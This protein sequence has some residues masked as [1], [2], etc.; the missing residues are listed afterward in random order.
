MPQRSTIPEPRPRAGARW[1]ELLAGAGL[2]VLLFTFYVAS[3][4]GK[5]WDSQFAALTSE[6]ILEGEGFDLSRFLAGTGWEGPTAVHPAADLPWQLERVEGRLLYLFPPGTPVL[7]LPLVAAARASGISSLDGDRRY[8]LARERRLQ[9]LV[10]SLLSALTA[11]IAFRLARYEVELRGALAVAFV[12]GLGSSLWTVASRELWSHTWSALLLGAGW[13]EL[14]R[15]ESGRARRPLLLGAIASAAFWVRPSNAWIA[16]AWTVFVGVRYRPQTWR[17][18]ASGAVGLGTYCA[19]SL[20]TSGALF[21]SYVRMSRPW[22][23]SSFAHG[24]SE[25]LFS[26]HHGILVYSPILFAAGYVLLRHGVPESK[27]PLAVLGSV[28]ILGHLGLHAA[29]GASWGP[30]G[31][32]L[33]HDL[34]PILAWFGAVALRRQHELGEGFAAPRRG[35]RLASAAVT[36]TLAGAS[37]LASI[38]SVQVGQRMMGRYRTSLEASYP[39]WDL[40]RLPQYLGLR[41]LGMAD[42]LPAPKRPSR[43]APAPE[44]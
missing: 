5:L 20:H 44:E 2:A 40:R 38:G 23:D 10:A 4:A 32:R 13:L 18:V 11:V 39:E 37:I 22:T 42:P 33:Q 27:R 19:W 29:S 14:L 26:T 24:L 31:P 12:A 34:V 43:R 6:A 8:D 3:P 15:W 28:L 7:S 9:L 30:D 16:V 1:I 41:A 36:I 35:I 17:L 25:I 21:P